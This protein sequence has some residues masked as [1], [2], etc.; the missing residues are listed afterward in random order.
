[1]KKKETKSVQ[2]T[3]R[4]VFQTYQK[5]FQT[6]LKKKISL[7]LQNLGWDSGWDCARV[8]FSHRESASSPGLCGPPLT[9]KS[10]LT[11]FKFS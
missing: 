1:M 4:K 11:C 10:N 5:V 9:F 2:R 3:S 7:I 6:I 8:G